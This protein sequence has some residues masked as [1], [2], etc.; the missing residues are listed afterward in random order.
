M[1]RSFSSN[2]EEGKPVT[3]LAIFETN[4]SMTHIRGLTMRVVNNSEEALNILFESQTNRA[5]AEHQLNDASS[6][7]HFLFTLHFV[8]RGRENEGSVVNSKLNIVDLAGR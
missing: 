3:A 6:R 7:S 2:Q 8:M 4:D 5:I 1:L